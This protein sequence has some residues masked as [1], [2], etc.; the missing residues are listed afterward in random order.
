MIMAVCILM[1]RRIYFVMMGSV[2]TVDIIL[3]LNLLLGELV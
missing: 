2:S 3:G 1:T